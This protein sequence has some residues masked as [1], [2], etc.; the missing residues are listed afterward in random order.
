MASDLR[1]PRPGEGWRHVK[2]NRLY[3]I[4]GTGHVTDTG[5]AVVIYREWGALTV[6][7][8][9]DPQLWVRALDEFLGWTDDHKRRFQFE[10]E[11]GDGS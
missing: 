9:R 5:R 3:E 4:T 11:A 6:Q 7:D 2:S 8:Q 1:M 10:R